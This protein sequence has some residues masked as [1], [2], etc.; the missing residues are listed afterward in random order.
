MVDQ[1]ALQLAQQSGKRD[2][3]AG[4]AADKMIIN[5]PGIHAHVQPGAAGQSGAGE[6]ALI[7]RIKAVLGEQTAVNQAQPRCHMPRPVRAQAVKH[8]G[9]ERA[10]ER[11][12]E[13]RGDEAVADGFDEQ[14][15]ALVSGIVGG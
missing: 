13:G 11:Q 8:P 3:A 1:A 5:Q 10:C 9:G 12:I 15:E 7:Q 6:Q 14:A 2:H 4:D